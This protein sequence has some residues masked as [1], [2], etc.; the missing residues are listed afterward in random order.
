MKSNYTFQHSKNTLTGL[1]GS[2][3]PELFHVKSGKLFLGHPVWD[4]MFTLFM[5]N[6]RLRET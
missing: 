3:F 2:I 1:L 4:E 5:N 6:R